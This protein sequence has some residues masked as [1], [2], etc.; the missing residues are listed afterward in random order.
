LD[1]GFTDGSKLLRGRLYYSGGYYDSQGHYVQK[2]AEFV[3]FAERILSA[4]RR[5][6][7]RSREL[8]ATV[9]DHAEALQKQGCRFRAP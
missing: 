4:A 3:R 9:G 5:W 6:G 8:R 7:K 2:S 1:G